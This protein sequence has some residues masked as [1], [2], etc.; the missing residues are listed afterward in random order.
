M[1]WRPLLFSLLA[2]C[3]GS[4]AQA[5]LTQPPS[6]SGSPGETVTI[7][8]TGSSS[9]IGGYYVQWYQQLSGVAPKLIIYGNSDRPSGVSDRYSGSK[10]GNTASLTISGLQSE[11]EADYYCGSYDSSLG[12]GRT[13][14]TLLISYLTS[15]GPSCVS[16]THPLPIFKSPPSCHLLLDHTPVLNVVDY[17]YILF[18]TL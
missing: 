2:H 6:V 16:V 14:P 5:V 13:S 1:A 8:C 11:D 12:D 15:D 3:T 4:W 18:L 10:S 17:F 7:S 9:N